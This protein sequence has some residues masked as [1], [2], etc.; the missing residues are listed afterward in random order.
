MNFLEK[1]KDDFAVYDKME[2]DFIDDEK[3]WDIKC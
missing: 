3:I 2:K 1:Y